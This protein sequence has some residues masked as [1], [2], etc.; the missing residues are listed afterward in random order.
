MRSI[1]KNQIHIGYEIG[2]AEKVSISPSH[3]IVTGV[4]QASGK[5]TTLQALIK[6]GQFKAI[7]FKTKIGEKGITEG[8]IIPPYYKD[9]FDWEYAS[10]LMEASRKEKLKFE[11]AWIIKYS[12]TATNLLEFKKNIDEAIPNVKRDLEKNVLITLQAYLDKILP[13]L[14]YAPLSNTLQL[15]EGINI[16]DLERFREETQG[17][18]IRSVLR[19]VLKKEKN[20]IIVIPEAWKYLPER[21]GSPV[22]RDAEAFIRQGATNNNYLWVDSQDITG[23]SK[24]ILKQVSI[25]I[26]GHQREINEIKR[27]IEQLPIPKKDR[28]TTND[29]ATLKVGHFYVATSDF[30]KKVYVQPSWLDGVTARKI[31]LGEVDVGTIKPPENISP[32]TLIGP[33]AK[34]PQT[35]TI[36]LQPIRQEINELRNDFFD[37]IQ[38]HQE[39]INKAYS[40]LFAIKTQN[41]KIDEDLIVGKVLQKIKIPTHENTPQVDEEQLI[42]KILSRIPR[43]S[44]ATVYEVAPLEKIQ[45]DFL[46]EIRQRMINDVSG[47]NDEQK[48]ILMF[49]ET[50]SK[51]CNQTHILSKGLFVSTTSGGTRQRVSKECKEMATLN[52]VRMDKNGVVYPLLEDRI[53]A[54]MG[55]HNA[56]EQEIELLYNHILMEIL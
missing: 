39:A 28:P 44:G 26:L 18:I 9:E 11:R 45:K 14:Q 37:K 35:V 3:L 49:V 1:G 54:L 12:K 56:K 24:T 46:E 30:T 25:W 33:E 6:R 32:F 16:M 27:T 7:I 13:E 48:K 38:Q 22:K 8:S 43:G 47:L 23:I 17:L 42:Q 40:E 36:D 2:T 15:K 50:Q 55:T 51:G 4:T 31:S 52:I 53:H 29:I 41:Q 19:E 5:T 20:T 10:D 21:V 34:E